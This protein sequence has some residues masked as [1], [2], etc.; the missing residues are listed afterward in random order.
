MAKR[1]SPIRW[2]S[3]VPLA[4]FL[5]V[6]GFFVRGLFLDST[7]VPS[8]LIGDSAPSFELPKLYSDSETFGPDQ[9]IG[10]PWILNVWASWCVACRDEHAVLIDLAARGIPIVGL[11]YKDE[12]KDARKWLRDWG[13]PYSVTAVDYEGAASID[14][15]VYGVPETFVID[16]AGI[17]LY[18]H[19]GPI[20][21][22][23]VQQEI[24]P[25]F[26][27]QAS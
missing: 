8:E 20:S 1:S 5:V 12:A 22:E 14:W 23:T 9:M 2:L 7:V 19:I 11:N 24:L 26:G 15:G 6:T 27:D 17:I 10:R 18:K 16:G 25:H 3:L 21:V 4:I 13:N